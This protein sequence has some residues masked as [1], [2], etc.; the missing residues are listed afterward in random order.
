MR[1][2]IPIA[3]S[4]SILIACNANPAIKEQQTTKRQSAVDLFKERCKS[5]GIKIHKRV[6]NVDGVM[7]I[8]VRFQPSSS[9]DQFT[10]SDPYGDDGVDD[11]YIRTFLRNYDSHNGTTKRD[12]PPYR[13]GF[14]FIEVQNEQTGHIDQ[15]TGAWSLIARKLPN[16]ASLKPDDDGLRKEFVL[17]KRIVTTPQAHYGVTFDDI[18]T[19]TDRSFWIAGSSLKIIDL[20]TKEVIAERIGYMMDVGQ[21]NNSGGRQPWSRAAA[22]A[23]PDFKDRLESQKI[24]KDLPPYSYQRMQTTDFVESVLIPSN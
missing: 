5:A 13:R 20:K 7:L 23:C 8:K 9:T 10:L 11:L 21:G 12:K 15:Y 4:T 24:L 17:S 22:N 19:W 3:I 6:E 1:I 16:G 18:S 2:Y 14:K